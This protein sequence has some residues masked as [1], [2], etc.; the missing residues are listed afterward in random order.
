MFKGE[1]NMSENRKRN[2]GTFVRMTEDEHENYLKLVKKSKLSQQE[3]NLNN[4]HQ[5]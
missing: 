1:K 2:K 3:Y 5:F 4:H